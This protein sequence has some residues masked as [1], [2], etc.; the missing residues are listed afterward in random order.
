M[1]YFTVQV[2]SAESEIVT[3]D[4]ELGHTTLTATAVYGDHKVSSPP[5][6]I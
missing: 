1:N 5:A 2:P 6:P 4:Y 3:V